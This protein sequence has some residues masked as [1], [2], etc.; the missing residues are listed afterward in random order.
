MRGVRA[1]LARLGGLF[2]RTRR[3]REFAEELESHLEMHIADNVR[4]GM[5]PESL[6]RSLPPAVP[7]V[8]EESG[9]LEKGRSRKVRGVVTYFSTSLLFHFSTFFPQAHGRNRS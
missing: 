7:P 6:R 4:R 2:G 8:F 1:W 3:D 9:K 5:T